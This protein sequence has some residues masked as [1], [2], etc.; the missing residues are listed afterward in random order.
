M[1]FIFI[2]EK[3]HEIKQFMLAD[4]HIHSIHSDGTQTPEEIVRMGARKKIVAMSITDH[5]TVSGSEEAQYAGEKYGVEVFPGVEVSVEFGDTAMHILGYCM[6]FRHKNLVSELT[7]LQNSRNERNIKIIEKLNL[8]G[9]NITLQEV[10]TASVYGQTGRPHIAKVL[11]QKKAVKNMQDAF[12][13]FLKKGRPAYMPRFVFSAEDAIHLIK[14]AG[15]YAILAH[16]MQID[17]TLVTLPSLLE[18][19]VTLGLDGIELHY[20][21]HSTQALKKLRKMTKDYDFLYTGGSDYHGDMRPG[22]S[23]ARGKKMM[24]SDEVLAQL[25]NKWIINQGFC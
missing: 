8:L 23:L 17:Q 6:N 18:K 10:E 12:E 13:R 25:R 16:P 14:Q 3:I 9:V 15:G 24:I 5:D 2:V 11:V 19:L 22:T 21:N 7:R 20:P 1:E 4:L